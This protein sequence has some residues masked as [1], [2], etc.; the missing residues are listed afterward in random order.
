MASSISPWA[1][2]NVIMHDQPLL[3]VFRVRSKEYKKRALQKVPLTLAPGIDV[4][5]GV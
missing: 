5:V 4:G 1:S 2:T 3:I